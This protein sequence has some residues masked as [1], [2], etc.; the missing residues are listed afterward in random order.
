MTAPRRT[1]L[2]V[3]IATTV[4]LL[5]A[6]GLLLKCFWHLRATD[7]GCLTDNVLTMGFSLSAKQYDTPDKAN[8]FKEQLLERVRAMPGLRAAGLSFLIPGAGPMGDDAFTIREHP[9]IASG[10]ALPSALY[11]TAD[12]GYFSALQIPLLSG[13]YFTSDDRTGRP[14]TVMVSRQL[15]NQYFP[16][17]DPLAIPLRCRNKLR[18]STRRCR[19]AMC[20]HCSRSMTS[21]WGM[22]A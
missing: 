18:R 11:A 5:I 12:P 7:V 4:V 13:R 3:E 14:N 22:P 20:F 15:A 1:L 17:E 19:S 6:A 8:A 9:P 16:G 2:T 10:H 21:P